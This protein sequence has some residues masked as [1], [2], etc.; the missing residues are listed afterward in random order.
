[1]AIEVFP[2]DYLVNEEDDDTMV[3]IKEAIA[4][5]RPVERTIWLK[6]VETD[7]YSAVAREYSV[8]VPT[9]KKYINEIKNKIISKLDNV[10]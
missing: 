1:M 10:I 4:D 8:S 9:A 7:N 6:Y 5:L 2:E 3:C